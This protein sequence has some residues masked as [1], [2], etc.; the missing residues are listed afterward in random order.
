MWKYFSTLILLVL[1]ILVIGFV[2]N[3]YYRNI[4]NPLHTD[5]QLAANFGELRP[6]HFHMG[7]DIRTNG[8]ENLPVYAIEEGYISLVKIELDGY[9][10]AIFLDHPDGK[11]SVYAHLNRFNDSLEAFVRRQQYA[12]KAWQQEIT[13]PSA[14]FPVKRGELIGYSGNT[15]RSEGP[16]LHF[17]LRDTRTGKNLNPALYGYSVTDHTAPVIQG[18][19]WYD[20]RYSTYERGPTPI[21]LMGEKGDYR[22]KKQIVKVSSP[23]VSLGI[24]ADDRV[25]DSRFRYGIYRAQVWLDDLLIHE[26]ALNNF[27]GSESRYV[28]ACIDYSNSVRSGLVIQHL[29]RLPGNLLP[30]YKGGDGL[31]HLKDTLQHRVHIRISDVAGNDTDL[32]FVL[33]HSNYDPVEH[34]LAP[35]A[36]MLKPGQSHVVI[37][38]HVEAQFDKNAFYDIVPFA[39]QVQKDNR[40]DAASALIRLHKPIVPVHSRYLVKIKT[41]LKPGDPLRRKS[42]IQLAGFKHKTVIKGVWDGNYLQGRF[43]ELGTVQVLIDTIAPVV[44][45]S[46]SNDGITLPEDARSISISVKD[47]LSEAFLLSAELDGRWVLFEQKGSVFTHFFDENCKTGKHILKIIV[48]DVAGNV[49]STRYKFVKQ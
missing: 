12:T 32:R 25:D 33:K 4:N 44:E 43:D 9:G 41:R 7:L 29:S 14:A 21:A 42:V 22:S 2:R 13:C 24:R 20:R 30:V 31:I 45:L 40:K 37:N 38:E 49:T 15:G 6:D 19:Y 18:L 11:T 17:E 39:L 28:N 3:N 23:V 47:N 1:V 27:S 48:S 10:K 46:G 5:L 16:H 26:F 34:D 35:V 8:K 36:R